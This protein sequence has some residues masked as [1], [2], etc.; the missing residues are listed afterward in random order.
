MAAVLG[1]RGEVAGWHARITAPAA[2]AATIARLTGS[3]D[4]RHA[5]KAEGAAIEGAVPPY[6]IPA[7]AIDHLPAD[8]GIATGIGRAMAHSYT[9]F[10]TECFVD[11]LARSAGIEPL[12]YRMQMLSGNTRLAHC[13]TTVTALGGWDGGTPGSNQGIAAHSCFGSHVAMLAE[14]HVGEGQQVVVDRV[15]A[16]VDCGR[17]IH[18]DIVA[19]QIESGIVWGIAA[20]TGATTGFTRGLADARNFDALDLPTLATTPE[21]RVELIPSREAPGGAGEIAVP[22]VAPAIANAIFAA[23]GR[24]LRSLPLAI[25]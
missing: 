24:R 18:P 9:A 14:A 7:I 4:G 25:G 22:P 19:Q 16:A 10:F 23:T 1:D 15:F 17:I 5:A 2:G 12:S 20:A 3:G 6:A 21:I 8:I 13:L 11:E